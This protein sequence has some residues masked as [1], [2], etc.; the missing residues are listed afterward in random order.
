MA[1]RSSASITRWR[2][3][4]VRQMNA[5]RR[6]TLAFVEQLPEA[7][8]LRS[9]TQDS[10]SVKDV[11]GHLLTCDE[12]T[13]R[14]LQLIARGRGDRIKWFESMAYADR[15]NARE[16]RR[17]RRFGLATI[18]RRMA[19][20]R[21]DLVR[22]LQRLPAASLQDPSHA[23]TVVSWL[24]VPGWTHERDHVNE[25]RHWWRRRRRELRGR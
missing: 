7:E 20:V 15:F 18:L 25:V 11:L 8:I 17:V 22:R 19:R 24:P 23:Y 13:V 10:W 1:S 21:A 4:A 12:E 16:V 6:S 9:R 14:R 3:H 2:K 5:V